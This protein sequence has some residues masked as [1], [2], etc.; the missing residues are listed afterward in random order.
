MSHSGCNTNTPVIL[1]G[2]G[3]V[4]NLI[5]PGKFGHLTTTSWAQLSGCIP[6]G[7]IDQTDSVM[8]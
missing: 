4:K 1:E 8:Y 6:V 5:S 7:K 3:P 2:S